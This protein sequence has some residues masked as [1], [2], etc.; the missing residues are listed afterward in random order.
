MSPYLTLTEAALYARCSKRTIQRWLD[1]GKLTRH[2]QS[3]PLVHQA[4]LQRFLSPTLSDTINPIA[5]TIHEG[6]A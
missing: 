5:K 4:E 3:R 6:S 1:A 2:G